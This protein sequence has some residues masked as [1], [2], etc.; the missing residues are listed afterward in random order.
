[1]LMNLSQRNT[2][3]LVAA[4]LFVILVGAWIFEAAGYPPCELCLM[5][6]WAYYVGIPMAGFMALAKPRWMTAGLVV[7]GMMLAANAV[8]GVYHAG[9]EWG[10]WQGPATCSGNGGLSDGGGSLLEKL[11]KPAVMCNEAALRILGLSLAGWNA[12]ICAAL[13]VM[14]LRGAYGSSSVSQ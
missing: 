12:V 13:A 11:K 8:F 2:A 4:V 10:W 7:L 6:R 1:M 3:T 5:Q 9:I 14:A